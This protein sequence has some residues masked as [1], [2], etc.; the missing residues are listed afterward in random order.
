MISTR[1]SKCPHENNCEKTTS[2]TYCYQKA[3]RNNA[4]RYGIVALQTRL[5]MNRRSS[6]ATRYES[7]L[8][9]W[10]SIWIVALQIRLDMNRVLKWNNIMKNH[11]P[12][13]AAWSAIGIGMYP[14]E[15]WQPR[16]QRVY[17]CK[18]WKKSAI[19]TIEFVRL[20]NDRPIAMQTKWKQI[21]STRHSLQ[22]R[23]ML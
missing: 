10:D 20:E 9:K 13:L 18:Q 6:N 12:H 17:T 21:P 15:V 5:D 22:R 19:E 4:T 1:R 14:K 3:F 8:F 2:Q 7:S 11:H 23:M 16:K